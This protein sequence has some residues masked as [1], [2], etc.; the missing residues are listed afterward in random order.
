[1]ST[2]NFVL[3][4][5][6]CSKCKKTLSILVDNKIEHEII[7]Y[8]DQ[9]PSIELLEE[10]CSGLGLTPQELIRSGEKSFLSS[11]YALEDERSREDWLKILQQNAGWIERPIV[12]IGNSYAIGRPPENILNII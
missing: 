9:S 5:P 10:I 12:K 1:M 7:S 2:S 6:A 8:L 11:P 4:N 3:Y